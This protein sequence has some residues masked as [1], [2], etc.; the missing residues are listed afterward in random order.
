MDLQSLIKKF[1]TS[2]TLPLGMDVGHSSVKLV[3][4]SRVPNQVDKFKLDFHGLIP[5]GSQDPDFIPKVQDYLKKNKLSGLTCAASFDDDKMKI[6]KLELAKMPE[7][8]LLEAIKWK[9]RDLVEGDIDDFIVRYSPLAEVGQVDARKLI[10]VGFMSPKEAVQN[11]KNTLLKL[12][13]KPYAVE[14]TAVSIAGCIDKQFDTT[15]NK[16]VGAIDI[17]QSRSLMV[18]VGNG[19]FHFS[20]PLTGVSVT[21]VNDPGSNFNQHLATEIQHTMDNFS[22][23]FQVEKLDKFLVCGGGAAIPG[24]AEYLTTNLAI[25]TS[26]VDPFLNVINPPKPPESFDDNWRPHLFCQAVSLAMTTF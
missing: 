25:D 18:V 5:V 7:A 14:P 8:D 11:T 9:M 17:G 2:K 3:K 26:V 22:I 23:A 13:L 24:I 12:G 1:G 20:R 4:L 10:V 19:K 16:W 15:E 6:R 21:D